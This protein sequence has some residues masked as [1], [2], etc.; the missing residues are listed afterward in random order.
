MRSIC[1][2]TIAALSLT[3]LV[4]PMTVGAATGNIS[5]TNK[6]AWSE[7]AGWA[8]LRPSHGGVMISGSHL[9]GYTWLEN[10][11]WVKLG[12]D[13]GGP[14]ANTDAS[15]WGVNHDGAGHLSGYAWS[16]T[17]GWIN[18]N[19]SHSQVTIDLATGDFAGYAW[20][21]NI[22]YIHFNNSSPAYKVNAILD[23]D[24]DGTPD[25]S[26]GCPADPA[27]TTAGVCGCGVADTDT[28]AD[29]IADCN[30][31]CN[32]L[33]DTDGDGV[34]DCVDGCPTN[35]TKTAPGFGG[36]A[37][38]EVEVEPAAEVTVNPGA[39]I[40]VT[41]AD[42]T[43]A[44]SLASAPTSVDMP[45][46]YQAI[47]DIY[48]ISTDCALSTATVCLTYDETKVHIS[49]LDLKLFHY[50]NNL[51]ED[52]TTT[53]DDVNN[54]VCGETTSFSPFVV[55]ELIG[56]VHVV[57]SPS[58]LSSLDTNLVVSFDASRSTCYDLAYDAMGIAYPVEL[59]CEYSWEFG[60]GGTGL[61]VGGNGD[62]HVVYQYDSPG[63]YTATLTM[64]EPI[65]GVTASKTVTA[66]AALV[67]PQGLSADFATAVNGNTVT[68]TAPT[69]DASVVRA[70]IY[71]GDRK[72]TV[73]TKPQVDLA[74]GIIYTYGRGGRDYNI[75]VQTID[76]AH[77]MTDYTFSEDGDLT[78]TIP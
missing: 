55:G 32:N 13:G 24:G 57:P 25:M 42:V 70:Y 54:T 30:D 20:G 19:C 58:A 22:G 9:S 14:Y 68:L 31:T 40:E 62:D 49:E 75:R 15:N 5:A 60:D 46:G 36:C 76:T 72:R 71:W 33:I 3:S 53:V 66:T 4:V 64:T 17:A 12:S 65:S 52:I 10:I 37:A 27:K 8:N 50:T 23:S 11:G 63:S 78:V 41:L 7:T 44:C 56:D 59:S 6:Y 2:Y 16:E 48:E 69:L 1:K 39:G 51:W 34:A 26:D 47:G 35:P 77:N 29:G 21:E 73:S 61:A 18:F 38:T 45:V 43:D 67:E 28:D 74:A